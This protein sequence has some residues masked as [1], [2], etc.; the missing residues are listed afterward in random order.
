METPINLTSY[1]REDLKYF[2]ALRERDEKSARIILRR[3]DAQIIEQVPEIPEW[4]V[5][6][7]QKAYRGKGF[8]NLVRSI[9]A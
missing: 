4:V 1:Y 6:E 3:M 9:L 8:T 2:L 5:P 7:Y